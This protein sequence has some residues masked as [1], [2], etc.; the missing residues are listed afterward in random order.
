MHTFIYKYICTYISFMA[1]RARWTSIRSFSGTI[2]EVL[3]VNCRMQIFNDFPTL[4][5]NLEKIRIKTGGGFS[6]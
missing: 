5:L 6:S 3:A 1:L 2:R 4:W